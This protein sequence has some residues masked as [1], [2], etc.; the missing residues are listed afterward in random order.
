MVEPVPTPAAH[1]GWPSRDPAGII[2]GYN[3]VAVEN[4]DFVN[5]FDFLGLRC[6]I[7]FDCTLSSE[8]D[9][10]LFSKQ[11][12]YDCDE[13]RRDDEHGFFGTVMCSDLDPEPWKIRIP[14]QVACIYGCDPS[15]TTVRYV[16]GADLK[17]DCSAALCTERCKAARKLAMAGTAPTGKV[18]LIKS[19]PDLAKIALIEAI[20]VAC[21]DACQSIC[22]KP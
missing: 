12:L 5:K 1:S 3:T 10:G 11:C 22:R 9:L 20:F 14:T 7:S 13:T 18:P 16:E 21:V 8:K 17:I 4:N 2:G 6:K 15:F 19:P